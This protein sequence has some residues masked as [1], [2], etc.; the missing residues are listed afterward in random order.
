MARIRT[1]KPEFWNDDKIG[2][3]NFMERL[4]YIGM[5]NFADDEGL[6]KASPLYLKAV[7][8]PYDNIKEADIQKA[9]DR[10]EKI[11]LIFH[12]G[13][14]NQKY[15]WIIKFRKHQRIDKPQKPTN[16]IPNIQSRLFKE[17]IFYRDGFV[18]HICGEGTSTE[19]KSNDCQSKNPS[20][21]HLI[22]ISK[23]GTHF[24]SNLATVCIHCN[25]SRGN[26]VIENSIPFPEDSQN[27][28]GI[29]SPEGKGKERKGK[30]R[31]EKKDIPPPPKTPPVKVKTP[32]PLDFSISERVRLW[33]SKEGFDQLQE[34]LEAFK[35]KVAMN[36]YRYINWDDAF[37]EA[38]R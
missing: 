18:C 6:I 9:L 36:G 26:K 16:P 38:I 28:R 3:L 2:S 32:I 13:Q 21:D 23:N 31:K 29:F 15:L 12:Y 24:P 17:A 5:W 10:M 7:I 30:E 27:N 19:D 14:V 34:H 22:P 1:I 20:V 35:R 25:K 37:M 33:A 11:K 4:L 8:F